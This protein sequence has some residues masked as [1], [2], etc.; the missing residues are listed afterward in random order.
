MSEPRSIPPGIVSAYVGIPMGTPVLNNPNSIFRQFPGQYRSRS[1]NPTAR[2]WYN[3]AYRNAGQIAITEP[4]KS[5]SLRI[6]EVPQP[7]QYCPAIS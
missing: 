2:G 4:Y 3:T 5:S 6:F 7:W 1:Y